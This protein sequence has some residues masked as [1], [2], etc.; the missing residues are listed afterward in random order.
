MPTTLLKSP[1]IKRS[2]TINGRKTAVSIETAFWD[3]LKSIAAERASSLNKLI[4]E[5]DKDRQRVN[6]SSALRLVVLARL[7]SRIAMTHRHRDCGEVG[8]AI[9]R[10]E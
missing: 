5:I 9:P 6:L 4:S 7:R 10:R 3:E 2:V 8:T 1:I